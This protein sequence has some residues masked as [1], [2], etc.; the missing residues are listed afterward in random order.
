MKA[1]RL[2][3]I[4]PLSSLTPD[5]QALDILC[6]EPEFIVSRFKYESNNSIS[7]ILQELSYFRPEII[8]IIG[9]SPNDSIQIASVIKE[10]NKTL[11]APIINLLAIH[12]IAEQLKTPSLEIDG[13]ISLPIQNRTLFI[14]TIKKRINY[15]RNIG[16]H[17][18]RDS[19]TG[20]LNH[21]QILEQLKI[22]IARA[23][24]ERS[25]LAFAMLDIDHFKNINDSYGHM[26]GDSIIEKIATLFESRL[27]KSDS[28]GR[29]G[30]D[31]F[32]IILPQSTAQNVYAILKAIQESFSNHPPQW[33]N[34]A[35]TATFSI[36]IAE[37][38]KNINSI[39]AL[40]QTADDALYNAKN[41]GRNHI[42]I[43]N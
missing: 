31:E 12:N 16:I 4:Q 41:K 11:I 26:A 19:L 6:S 37:L 9:L 40:V 34:T 29:Y 5:M 3:L 17:L 30:G 33:P 23:Q 1:F 21:A 38:S 2:Y 27:R 8:L 13:L 20:L 35:F 28:I 10:Q 15:M 22:E 18:I 14:N 7:N 43:A 24:R 39:P 36:G 32:A 42:I 25:S